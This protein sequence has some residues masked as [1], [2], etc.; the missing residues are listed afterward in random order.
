MAKA[1][2]LRVLI[3]AL[4]FLLAGASGLCTITANCSLL[5]PYNYNPAVPAPLV[6]ALHGDGGGYDIISNF[7][8]TWANQTGYVVFAPQCPGNLGCATPSVSCATG[9]CWLDGSW[10]PQ[11]IGGSIAW[12]KQITAQ[13]Q[14]T[15]NLDVLRTYLLGASGGAYYIGY[16]TGVWGK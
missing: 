15:Y 10:H 14:A 16:H 5:F 11:G 3:A 6:V 8:A 9:Y 1:G 4:L 12:L 13:V 7:L 2:D